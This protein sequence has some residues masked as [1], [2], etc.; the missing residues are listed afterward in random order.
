MHSRR[1]PPDPEKT[2]AA[3]GERT[4]KHKCVQC[5]REVPAEEYLANDF[6]CNECAAKEEYPLAS[7]PSKDQG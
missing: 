2:T 1:L 3:P 7:T 5:L 4:G 6:L